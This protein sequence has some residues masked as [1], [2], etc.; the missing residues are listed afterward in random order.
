MQRKSEV[1]MK[2]EKENSLKSINLDSLIRIS[3]NWIPIDSSKKFENVVS[4][5][6]V[7]D[8]PDRMT[9]EDIVDAER[10]IEITPKSS[11]S[12]A[13]NIEIKVKNRQKIKCIGIVSEASVL[14]IFR[15][16]GEY[17]FT[18]FPELIDEFQGSTVYYTKIA[19]NISTYETS[20]KFTRIKNNRSTIFLYGIKLILDESQNIFPPKNSHFN[21]IINLIAD[22]LNDHK[23]HEK[24]DINTNNWKTTHQNDSYDPNILL[25]VDLKLKEME[26]RII[27]RVCLMETNI[28]KK[29]NEIQN[30]LK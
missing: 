27:Q 17:A 14:E 13:C 7:A 26:K 2:T 3:C 19:F 23:E 4:L 22:S 18:V 30:L 29:L 24:Y 10:C 28:E 1:C 6:S 25:Y 8:I 15:E 11:D 20:I 12:E 5:G 16:N 9:L 21:S